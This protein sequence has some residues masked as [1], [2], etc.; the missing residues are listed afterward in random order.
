M[1]VNLSSGIDLKFSF[2]YLL[3]VFS[4]LYYDR[5]QKTTTPM[6]R[7]S[8]LSNLM[9]V[10][11]TLIVVFMVASSSAGADESNLLSPRWSPNVLGQDWPMNP[12]PAATT[13]Y[14]TDVRPTF[15]A[16]PINPARV[17]D[18]ALEPN[19]PRMQ[20][21]LATTTW[22][23][24]AFSTEAEVAANQAGTGETHNAMPNQAADPSSRMMRLGLT[25]FSGPTRYGVTYRHAGQAFYNRSDQAV[26]EVWGEWKQGVTTL[27]SAIGQ[28]WNNVDA[29]PT[30]PRI[31]QQY[32]RVGLSLGK[33]A[34]PTVSVMISQRAIESTLDP[35][36]VT[37]QKTN[38]QTLEAAIAYGRT[39]WTAGFASS[40]RVENDLTHSGLDKRIN[41][42]QLTAAFHPSSTLTLAPTLGYR[43]ERQEWSGVRIESPSASLAMN[44]RQSQRLLLGAMGN[45]SETRSS[46]RL[47]DLETVGGKGTVALDLQTSREWQSQLSFEAGYNRQLNRSVPSAQTEDV[48]GILRLMLV[49]P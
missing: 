36:A 18:L 32:G 13:G 49:P 39:S 20:G 7:S 4:Y 24:W 35:I 38:A 23:K 47:T 26:K 16:A 40:L 12:K 41:T 34:W 21:L 11:L 14:Q 27:T 17:R 43:M 33:P 42:Q 8:R 44:Y 28:Q 45:L 9:P 10:F 29:D 25:G 1:L 22:P 2:T 15:Y 46:D 19:R 5:L 31:G 3:N 37:P 6:H 48:S 30:R